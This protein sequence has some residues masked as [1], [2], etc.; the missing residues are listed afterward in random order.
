MC[1]F[2]Y[3]LPVITGFI[4][5][6]CTT[7]GVHDRVA[8]EQLRLA[9][10]MRTARLC[11]Y[12]DD[13]ISLQRVQM[14]LADAWDA[15]AEGIGI[16]WTIADSRPWPRSAFTYFSLREAI[17]RL[18]LPPHCDRSML[19]LGRHI[20]DVLWGLAAVV[21]PLPEVA[22]YVDNNA[23]LRGYVVATRAT[24]LQVIWLTPASTLRHELYHML[25]CDEGLSLAPCYRVIQAL[26][27]ASRGQQFF[28]ARVG[29]SGERIIAIQR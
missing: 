2:L 19:F 22:G 26:K 5:V 10:E 7:V 3:L 6:G 16:R 28:A 12:L 15:D 9:E 29:W 11:A 21:L 24:L 17:D 14:L 18:P 1:C 4:V 8:R 20:G 25:G 23:H 27:A 13:G